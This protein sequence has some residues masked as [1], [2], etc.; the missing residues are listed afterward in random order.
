MKRTPQIFS[1]F[2]ILRIGYVLLYW[3]L[4]L[5]WFGRYKIGISNNAKRRRKEVDKDLPGGVVTVLKIPVY[6]NRTKETY[7]HNLF[8]S[9][10]YKPKRAGK[11]AGK[12]EHFKLNWFDVVK[13]KAIY[14]F[15]F[16]KS[17]IVGALVVCFILWRVL[18]EYNGSINP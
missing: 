4:P 11:G 2:K 12:S 1:R 14:L 17:N 10:N 3:L 18:I 13:A 7:L 15:F 9:K 6:K 8:K 5:L 16:I